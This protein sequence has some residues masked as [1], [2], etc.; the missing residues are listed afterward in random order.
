MRFP[1]AHSTIWGRVSGGFVDGRRD[2]VWGGLAF[3]VR[4]LFEGRGE[5]IRMGIIAAVAERKRIIEL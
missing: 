3:I 5:R 1:K 2:E 4:V